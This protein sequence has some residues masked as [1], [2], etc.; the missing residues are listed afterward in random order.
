MS[1]LVLGVVLCMVA[2]CRYPSNFIKLQRANC[3]D[4]R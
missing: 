2:A 1:P 3:S 4:W